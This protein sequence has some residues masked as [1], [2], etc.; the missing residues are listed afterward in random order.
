MAFQSWENFGKFKNGAL[1]KFELLG[2]WPNLLDFK[3]SRDLMSLR[4]LLIIFTIIFFVFVRF[5]KFL[6]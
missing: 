4:Y 2:K 6:F 5:E 1:S 3:H